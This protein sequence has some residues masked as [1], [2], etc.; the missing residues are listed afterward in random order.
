MS[1]AAEPAESKC[2][3][4]LVA[5]VAQLH[6]G[7]IS[8]VKPC[9]RQGAIRVRVCGAGYLSTLIAAAPS[10]SWERICDQAMNERSAPAPMFFSG[11]TMVSP[12]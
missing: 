2:Q 5:G 6:G 8:A 9:D 10:P 12:G 11:T 3:R 1:D 7:E 4:P